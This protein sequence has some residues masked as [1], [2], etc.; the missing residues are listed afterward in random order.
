MKT[1]LDLN[2]YIEKVMFQHLG[3]SGP[4]KKV[5]SQKKG[6]VLINQ[7]DRDW[8]SGKSLETKDLET[9]VQKMKNNAFFA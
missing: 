3:L 4:F 7:L 8:D 2:K 9:I 1:K 5:L 6:Y